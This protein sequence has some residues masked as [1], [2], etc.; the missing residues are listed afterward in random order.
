MKGRAPQ[1]RSRHSRLAG[2]AFAT[3]LLCAPTALAGPT[4]QDANGDT[5]RCGT[6]GALPVGQAPPPGLRAPDRGA[7]HLTPAAIFGLVCVIG[8]VFGLIA[9][10]P[11]FGGDW[12]KQQ[13]DDDED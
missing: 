4:C 11:R 10:M 13:G 12:D 9:L 8:G 6:D 1:I 7:S 5:I 3:S 2:V